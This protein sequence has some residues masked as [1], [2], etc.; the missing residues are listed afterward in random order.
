MVGSTGTLMTMRIVRSKLRKRESASPVDVET[1]QV[2]SASSDTTSTPP[3]AFRQTP[4]SVWV[5]PPLP[6][7][8]NIYL[9]NANS[10]VR[11]YPFYYSYIII[12]YIC[13]KISYYP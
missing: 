6:P 3:I 10:Q 8:P 5:F 12:L 2:I 1:P 4:S 11:S 7:Q 13:L 9:Y